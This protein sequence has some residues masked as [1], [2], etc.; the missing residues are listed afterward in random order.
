MSCAAS[1]ARAPPRL[2][3]VTHTLAALLIRPASK[4]PCHATLSLSGGAIGR[5]VRT[6]PCLM[7][8]NP[9]SS[10]AHNTQPVSPISVQGQKRDADRAHACLERRQRHART[11]SHGRQNVPG[12]P[13]EDPTLAGS[14][15]LTPMPGRSLCA[16]AAVCAEA[17][18]ASLNDAWSATPAAGRRMPFSKHPRLHPSCQCPTDCLSL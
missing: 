9:Q 12:V 15:L 13:A 1:T 2:C 18:E 16:P 11:A 5:A 17:G 8:W 14:A 10:S 4:R 6:C 3:P 7:L